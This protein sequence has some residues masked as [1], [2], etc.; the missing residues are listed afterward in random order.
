MRNNLNGIRLA[1]YSVLRISQNQARRKSEQVKDRIEV[2]DEGNERRS[3]AESPVSGANEVNGITITMDV[4][5]ERTLK[6]Q[7]R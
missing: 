6:L 4:V 3:V 5:P 2:C 1:T 7:V